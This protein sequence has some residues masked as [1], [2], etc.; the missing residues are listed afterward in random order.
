MYFFCNKGV[1]LTDDTHFGCH[2]QHKYYRRGEHKEL[3]K[4]REMKGRKTSGNTQQRNSMAEN[5]VRE[6]HV[7]CKPAM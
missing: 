7:K 5:K 4:G 3:W 1:R 6:L 2:L